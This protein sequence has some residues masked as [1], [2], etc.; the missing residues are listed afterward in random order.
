MLV[1]QDPFRTSGMIEW[2]MPADIRSFED[3]ERF[4][5][6]AAGGAGLDPE[7]PLF[8]AT[9]RQDLS[10]SISSIASATFRTSVHENTRL[11]SKR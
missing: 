9:G 2:P 4:V 6:Q 7:K 3:L 10:N 8:L 1:T 5:P 11:N